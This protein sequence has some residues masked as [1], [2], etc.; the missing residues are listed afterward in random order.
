MANAIYN[1]SL[2]I[3]K[4]IHLNNISVDE[5][6]TTEIKSKC[7]YFTTLCYISLDITTYYVL[8]FKL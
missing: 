7:L 8:N 4:N 2:K 6:Q 5:K 3:S 1:F